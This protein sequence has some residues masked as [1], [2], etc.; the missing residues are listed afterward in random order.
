MLVYLSTDAAYLTTLSVPQAKRCQ[1]TEN[2][3]VAGL[4]KE[5]VV[6]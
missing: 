1:N 5:R 4:R 3:E 6:A 2:S